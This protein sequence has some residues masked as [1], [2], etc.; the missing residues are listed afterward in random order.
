MAACQ[1]GCVENPGAHETPEDFHF[2]WRQRFINM[3][4]EDSMDSFLRNLSCIQLQEYHAF[5]SSNCLCNIMILCSTEIIFVVGVEEPPNISK[6][7][8]F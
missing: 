2:L 1:I 7:I 5:H 4:H 8:I 6:I 3:V